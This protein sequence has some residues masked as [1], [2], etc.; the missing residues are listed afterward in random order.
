MTSSRARQLWESRSPPSKLT[1]VD[2]RISIVVRQIIRGHLSKL[3][4][5]AVGCPDTLTGGR[6]FSKRQLLQRS[7]IDTYK[8][9]RTEFVRSHKNQGGIH[10]PLFSFAAYSFCF[11]ARGVRHPLGRIADRQAEAAG[12]QPMS[13]RFIS[14]LIILPGFAGCELSIGPV[15]DEEAEVG[16]PSDVAINHRNYEARH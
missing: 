16:A 11:V 14:I 5:L 4:Q 2:V 3:A 15:R 7:Y 10:A 8:V 12:G 13:Q 6:S 9:G 1:P